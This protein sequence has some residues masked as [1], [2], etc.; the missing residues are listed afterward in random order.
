MPLVQERY[1]VFSFYF[2]FFYN[3]FFRTMF[4][5]VVKVY[6]I[7]PRFSPGSD[8]AQLDLARKRLIELKKK[9]SKLTA[10]LILYWLGFCCENFLFYR[11]KHC[12]NLEPSK[13][14][15]HHLLTVDIL[16]KIWGKDP[17]EHPLRHH[18]RVRSSSFAWWERDRVSRDDKDK[19]WKF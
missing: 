10:I 12:L 19:E 9:N 11:K 18:I 1:F 4:L 14:E 16:T 5:E 13:V 17:M 15:S 7:E 8:S 2:F 3:F 6:E